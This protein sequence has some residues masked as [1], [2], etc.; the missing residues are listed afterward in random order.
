[1]KLHIPW[2]PSVNTYWRNVNGRMM[3]SKQGR[4]YRKNIAQMAMQ[5]RWERFMADRLSVTIN[6]YPPDRRKR[7]LDNLPKAIFDSLQHAGIFDDDEQIDFFSVQRGQII[8]PGR[9]TLTITRR[10]VADLEVPSDA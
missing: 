2:P 4:L 8:K 10:G 1:M 5:N 7:D 6:A 3:I 9:V